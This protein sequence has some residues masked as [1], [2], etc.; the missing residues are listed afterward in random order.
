MREP[1]IIVGC[2]VVSG[3]ALH[4]VFGEWIGA[5][6]KAF[7]DTGI[8]LQ[9]LDWHLGNGVVAQVGIRPGID[10]QHASRDFGDAGMA[11]VQ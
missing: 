8:D 3:D 2:P 7:T 10:A 5:E 6:V 11:Q 4:A 1:E 9:E